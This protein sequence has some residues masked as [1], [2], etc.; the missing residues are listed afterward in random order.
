M[1]KNK[2]EKERRKLNVGVAPLGDPINEQLNEAPM[3]EREEDD[4]N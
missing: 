1:R 2:D 4:I 3:P